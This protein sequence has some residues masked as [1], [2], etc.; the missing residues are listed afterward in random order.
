LNLG[1][2]ENPYSDPNEAKKWN[3]HTSHRML[4]KKA[5]LESIVLLKNDHKTLPI[6]KKIRSVAVI[7][8][9][10]DEARLGGYSGPGNKKVSI[11]DAVRSKCRNQYKS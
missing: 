9:D 4:S 6:S 5:A 10:A 7:G 1:L 2:F 8:P 3:G 11:L